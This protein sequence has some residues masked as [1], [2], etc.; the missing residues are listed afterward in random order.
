MVRIEAAD[1]TPEGRAVLFHVEDTGPGIAPADIERIFAPFEQAGDDGARRVG[2]G[3]GLAIS[4]RI[5][6]QMGGRIEAQS[7]PGEGSTFTVALRLDVVH[8]EAMARAS[9]PPPGEPLR[10]PSPEVRARLFALAERGRLQEIGQELLALEAED[11][12][13]GPWLR[14]ARA[15]AEEFRVHELCAMLAAPDGE[16]AP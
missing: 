5:V 7:R 12:A 8:E 1:D 10:A 6:E 14:Q 11:P 2:A 16:P 15:L 4:R 9:T 13:L 3:L